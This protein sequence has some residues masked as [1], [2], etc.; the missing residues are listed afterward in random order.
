MPGDL[1]KMFLDRARPSSKAD[2]LALEL[3]ITDRADK[4][5][6]SEDLRVGARILHLPLW[7]TGEGIRTGILRPEWAVLK[8]VEHVMLHSG[9]VSTNSSKPLII[10][11]PAIDPE[12][13]P[14]MSRLSI[15]FYPNPSDALI[16]FPC[17]VIDSIRRVT[18]SW[19]AMRLGLVLELPGVTHVSFFETE[20]AAFSQFARMSHL[21]DLQDLH[22]NGQKAHI[23]HKNGRTHV[24]F[25]D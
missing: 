17:T 12:C 22:L 6:L 19:I 14:N 21:P 23:E 2:E 1:E 10:R 5:D 8:N 25:P 16:I 18:D 7:C 13:V 4:P 3:Y 11:D 20:T 15:M 9:T 24:A